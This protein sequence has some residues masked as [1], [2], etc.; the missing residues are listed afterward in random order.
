[1]VCE[2]ATQEHFLS[3][4]RLAVEIFYGFL[5]LPAPIRI[6]RLLA[7]KMVAHGAPFDERADGLRLRRHAPV[8]NCLLFRQR[9]DEEQEHQGKHQTDALK[10]VKSVFVS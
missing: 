3:P 6:I 7:A 2:M 8:K 10:G 1:M 5:D 4:Q 9:L